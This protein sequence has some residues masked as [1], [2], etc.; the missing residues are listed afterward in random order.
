[1]KDIATQMQALDDF[2]TRAR[3]QNTQHHD[4]HIRSLGGLSA[5]VKSSFGDIGSHFSSS[6]ER[7]RDGGDQIS[8]NIATLQASL[9]PLDATV[10]QPLADLRSIVSNTALQEYQPTGETPQKVQY[11]YPVE[12]PRTEAHSN[13]LAALR[14]P[15]NASPSKTTSIPVIFN[16]AP[17][18]RDDDA[19]PSEEGE[20]KPALGLREVHVNI[21]AGSHISDDG[22]STAAAKP[23]V[24][25][26]Y[27]SR[28]APAPIPG[29]KRS[30][31]AGRLAMPKSARKASPVV[32][33][34]GREN[35]LFSQSTGRRRSPRLG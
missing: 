4:S 1:M 22:V 24:Q 10:N 7:L 15:V 21:N 35:A 12:L 14:R 11:L 19:T 6:Y 5:R 9:E 2:V 13:L 31:S 23:S 8:A 3:S 30:G 34:E 29:F 32:A 28:D 18:E 16:D 27:P 17:D 26:T 25:Q 20:R 33:L